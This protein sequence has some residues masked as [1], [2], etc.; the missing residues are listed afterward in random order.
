[1]DGSIE[2]TAGE[3]KRLLMTYRSGTDSRV[4]RRAHIVL[5]R[6]AGWTWNRI[7]EALF[8]SNDL[9]AETLRTWATGGIDAIVETPSAHAPIPAWLLKTLNWISRHTPQDFGF[10]R[11]RWSCECLS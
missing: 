3:R 1:M 8:C 10:F 7:R 5:L 11:A 2:L 6:A 4:S 9:I